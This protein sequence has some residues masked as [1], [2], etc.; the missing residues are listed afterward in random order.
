MSE[1]ILN[2]SELRGTKTEDL[3]RQL[4]EFKQSLFNLRFQHHTG[5]LENFM[6]I[7]HV[8]RNIARIHTIL[9]ERDIAKK[10]VQVDIALQEN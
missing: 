5:Q 3:G 6:R 4:D 2:P 10:E 1:N 9:R 8:K 7:T